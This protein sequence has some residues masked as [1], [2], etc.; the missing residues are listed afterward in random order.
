MSKYNFGWFMLFLTVSFV[1]AQPDTLWT[2]TFGGS[3]RE[4]GYCL[5]KNKDGGYILLGFTQSFGAGGS[6]VWVIKTD[7]LGNKIWDKTYGDGKD[8]E[9]YWLE[10][11]RDG[12]YIIVGKKGYYPHQF[13]VYLIKIDSL[14]NTMWE[15]TFGGNGEDVGY[16]VQQTPEGGYIIA[17]FTESYGKGSYDVWI[18]K[19]DSLG[20]KLWDKTYGGEGKDEAKTIIST[21]DGNYIIGG[22]TQSFGA[23]RADIWII[24]ID[25]VGNIIW[26]KIYGQDNWDVVFSIQE[27]SDK[28]YIAT[29]MMWSSVPYDVYVLKMDSLGNKMWERTFGTPVYDV[30][31]CVQ[32]TKDGGYIIAGFTYSSGNDDLWLIKV[33]SLGNK[34]WDKTWGGNKMDEGYCVQQTSDGGYAVLGFT[35]S[36]GF[37]RDMWLIKTTSAPDVGVSNILN[38]HDIKLGDSIVPK[39]VVENFSNI[40]VY[41]ISVSSKI[42]KEN[43]VVYKKMR[44]IDSLTPW[45]IDTIIF[46]VYKPKQVDGYTLVAFT[47]MPNDEHPRNDTFTVTFECLGVEESHSTL[48]FNQDLKL[49]ISSSNNTIEISYQLP[50]ESLLSIQIYDIKGRLVKTLVNETQKKGFNKIVWNRTDE[51]MRKVSNGIYFLRVNSENWKGVKKFVIF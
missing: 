43:S 46:P 35:E 24:K 29:G 30:G 19:T 8:E 41:N 11:T 31:R 16:S 26:D 34:L 44:I 12:G 28:G 1:Y 20:N 33:D 25:S 38:V 23:G 45:E 21:S 42:F 17:G 32:E 9:G 47:T 14:G 51:N 7:S 5:K 27:T 13:D 3:G 2:K 49:L 4:W 48:S 15:K 37:G 18:I 6:D 50:K 40:R 10:K 22:Y 39:I 36:F